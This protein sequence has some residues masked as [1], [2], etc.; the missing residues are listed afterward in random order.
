MSV[1]PRQSQIFDFYRL[2][3]SM[4]HHLIL[5]LPRDTNPHALSLSHAKHTIIIIA[6]ISFAYLGR[7]FVDGLRLFK[8]PPTPDTAAHPTRRLDY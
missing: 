7:N 4:F 6:T 8:R 5:I 2:T 3:L 1:E